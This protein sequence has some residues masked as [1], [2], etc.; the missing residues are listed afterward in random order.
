MNVTSMTASL[1]MQN[2]ISRSC[3]LYFEVNQ[4]ITFTQT[5]TD[6]FKKNVLDSTACYEVVQADCT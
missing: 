4:Y 3:Q 6:I 1:F 2:F 5:S